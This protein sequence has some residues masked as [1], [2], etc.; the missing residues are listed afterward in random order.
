MSLSRSFIIVVHALL[1][2]V[3]PLALSAQLNISGRITDVNNEPIEFATVRVG[4]TVIGAVSGLKGEYSLSCPVTDT[5]T[6]HF[7]CMGFRD[8]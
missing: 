5:V 4:G 1:L 6:V 3:V 8:Q 2:S 7:S